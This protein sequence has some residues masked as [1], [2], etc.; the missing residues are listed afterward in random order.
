MRA[1]LPPPS[2]ADQR[3]HISATATAGRSQHAA[4]EGRVVQP[5]RHRRTTFEGAVKNRDP[6]SRSEGATRHCM[7]RT[8]GWIHNECQTKEISVVSRKCGHL[9]QNLEAV[10]TTCGPLFRLINERVRRL[11]TNDYLVNTPS[12]PLTLNCN[13]TTTTL[14]VEPFDVVHVPPT[15]TAYNAQI[16]IM[17]QPKAPS[18]QAED[19]TIE[20]SLPTRVLKGHAIYSELEESNEV[21]E[22]A[23][24]ERMCKEEEDAEGWGLGTRYNWLVGALVAAL[25]ALCAGGVQLTGGAAAVEARPISNACRRLPPLEGSLPV[26][27]VFWTKASSWRLKRRA[28][29]TNRNAYQSPSGYKEP[30]TFARQPVGLPLSPKRDKE[31]ISDRVG[32]PGA[33]EDTNFFEDNVQTPAPVRRHIRPGGETEHG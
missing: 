16:N 9:K 22:K 5:T 1:R 14:H 4:A 11:G 25:S 23:E 19:V 33:T 15:C 21:E 2:S 26:K 6:R 10:G 8:Q 3:L 17:I 31:G 7:D 12:F 28:D 20:F 32:H 24:A 13:R 27:A 30:Q 18:I 29:Q